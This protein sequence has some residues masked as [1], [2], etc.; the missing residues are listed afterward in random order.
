M[1]EDPKH[2]LRIDSHKLENVKFSDTCAT[3]AQIYK[4]LL[5]DG[6]LPAIGRT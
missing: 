2:A 6:K 1:F 4:Y 3:V 5:K